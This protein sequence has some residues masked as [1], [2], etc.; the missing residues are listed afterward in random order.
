[1]LFAA[2]LPAFMAVASAGSTANTIKFINHCPYDVFSWTVGPDGSGF[3]GEDHQAVTI[4]ANTVTAHGMVSGETVGGGISL[5]LRDLPKYR[6]APAGIVQVDYKLEGSKNN[7]WYDLSAVNCNHAA[8]PEDPSFCP[9]IRSGMKVHVEN[10]DH[11]QCLP[12]WCDADGCHNTYKEHGSWKGEPTFRCDAGTNIVIEFCTERSGP[13]T[14]NGY[15]EPGHSD[16]PKPEAEP[17][18]PTTNGICGVE[19]PDGATCFGF[20]HGNCCSRKPLFIR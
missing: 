10:A 9:L 2:L 8:G 15:A 17:G 14:F 19:S 6:I 3:D 1:M 13:R 20:A 11:A 18:H 12:A 7:L 5:K 16:E 4:P